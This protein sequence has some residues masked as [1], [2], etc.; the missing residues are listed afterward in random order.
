MLY[1]KKFEFKGQQVNYYNKVRK[2]PKV[3]LCWMET[4]AKLGYVV[5]WKYKE[6]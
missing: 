2:N 1:T 5:C 6:K 3:A 4:N